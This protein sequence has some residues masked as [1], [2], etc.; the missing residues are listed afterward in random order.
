MNYVPNLPIESSSNSFD[1]HVID[2]RNIK[3]TRVIGTTSIDQKIFT[4]TAIK[5]ILITYETELTNKIV[6][7]KSGSILPGFERLTSDTIIFNAD[8]TIGTNY[9][10][11]ISKEDTLY[12]N[13]IILVEDYITDLILYTYTS[14]LTI[15]KTSTDNKLS[16]S[17]YTCFTTTPQSAD[18]PIY[19]TYSFDGLTITN[20]TLILA[21][22]QAVSDP[23]TY[24]AYKLDSPSFPSHMVNPREYKADQLASN[25]KADIVAVGDNKTS[26]TVKVYEKI[27]NTW[28]QIGSNIPINNI[29]ASH[30]RVSMQPSIALN[31]AGNILVVGSPLNDQQETDEG[32]DEG[33][34]KI[35]KYDGSEWNQM[36]S[37]IY[38]DYAGGQL[39]YCVDINLEGNIVAVSQPY[40]NEN[41]GAVS[42][43]KWNGV[44]WILMGGLHLVNPTPEDIKKNF[45]R[46]VSLDGSGYTIAIGSNFNNWGEAFVFR[47]DGTNWNSYYKTILYLH[48]ETTSF[49][50]GTEVKLSSDSNI[51]IVTN[52]SINWVTIFRWDGTDWNQIGERL[53]ING[54]GNLGTSEFGNNVI[55]SR[56]NKR[57]IVSSDWYNSV[58]VYEYDD[59]SELY[60]QK[61]LLRV[62]N[63]FGLL[64]ADITP[65]F[66][67]GDKHT[68][69]NLINIH[70][71][72]L[73]VNGY[74]I[75]PDYWIN[76]PD[77]PL[78][79]GDLFEFSLIDKRDLSDNEII[80][81]SDM[82]KQTF[83]KNAIIDIFALYE[84]E[85]I[86]KKIIFKKGIILPGFTTLSN[87]TV[88]INRD[89]TSAGAYSSNDISKEYIMDKDFLI[90][91]QDKVE[92]LIIPTETAYITINKTDNDLE[93]T[94]KSDVGN[95]TSSKAMNNKIITV[96]SNN[97]YFFDGLTIY[98]SDIFITGSLNRQI[99]SYKN[100]SIPINITYNIK[101]IMYLQRDYAPHMDFNYKGDI[102]GLY[103]HTYPGKVEVFKLTDTTW[104]KIG[105][106]IFLPE[107]GGRS[108]PGERIVLSN[109]GYT[110]SI[111]YYTYSEDPGEISVY[112]YDNTTN[113]WIQKGNDIIN[114]LIPSYGHSIS[115]SSD[116]NTIVSG[117]YEN[118]N[119][120]VYVYKWDGTNWNTQGQNIEIGM[121]KFIA[122]YVSLN[123][124]GT[125]LA[126]SHMN[127]SSIKYIRVY[128]W[129][130]E[131]WMQRGDDISG[132]DECKLNED[133]TILIVALQYGGRSFKPQVYK[134]D[135][136]SWNIYDNDFYKADWFGSAITISSDNKK[137]C[138]NNG[139]G[140]RV[141]YYELNEPINKW[142]EVGHFIG[143]LDS[144][145]SWCATMTSNE[146][147]C[148]VFAGVNDVGNDLQIYRFYPQNTIDV[149]NVNTE[150]NIVELISLPENDVTE[151]STQAEKIEF[152][153]SLL[154]SLVN[155]S[156]IN[157]VA[158]ISSDIVLPGFEEL[159][160]NEVTIFDTE[161][162]SDSN[163]DTN[164]EIK[165][166][167]FINNK[168]SETEI[169]F[170]D[171]TVTTNI[172]L[173][174][175]KRN[176]GS[177]F[178][179]NK[180]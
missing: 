65:Y 108:N 149:Q 119:S 117:S 56:D 5:N 121:D 82:E 175:I 135:G 36:G 63:N 173:G 155:G 147:D 172:Q 93:L 111:S 52:Y 102:I 16:V 33:D 66:L 26:N 171:K 1:F 166:F 130:E 86:N 164:S 105:N 109:S 14:L 170:G 41:L 101:S 160:G 94:L 169:A 37:I 127:S 123:S 9:S 59:I 21:S 47:W 163:V 68:S 54:I 96:T 83:T 88:I 131:Y 153:K 124:Y 49:T 137:I 144:P 51:L 3:D 28:T 40:A 61:G 103:E 73:T 98:N 145:R 125:V 178:I 22:L 12:K 112:T 114:E 43:Y 132:Y 25:Y 128:E 104:S 77:L 8:S 176:T 76:V 120:G 69:V 154:T 150:D 39:G 162:S 31:S 110:F 80:G 167:I 17:P 53:V 58:I 116:G 142:E 97:Y 174:T 152:S 57:I 7:L 24:F 81:S 35:Y 141:Y 62:N 70:N 71:E 87:D 136:N 177:L 106:T 133:G 92:D 84:R 34:V 158:T 95:R 30:K 55:I 78:E 156:E 165:N 113:T 11:T 91:I 67:V 79:N 138:M 15:N 90:L 143:N 18:I 159:Q 100:Y 23:G 60:I 74:A 20:D 115:M 45:G 151:D 32:T 180:L 89:F 10:T 157:S 146:Y 129:D 179:M 148:A 13:C 126:V 122:Q 139:G 64:P 107:S 134:W 27:N 72:T 19:D 42:V 75:Q 2:T 6:I 46:F 161:S 44:D 118:N 85:L 168:G 4:Q 50:I 29:I 38:G 48:N 99:N 140:S